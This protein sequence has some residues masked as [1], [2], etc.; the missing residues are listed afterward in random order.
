MKA[1]LLLPAMVFVLPCQAQDEKPGPSALEVPPVIEVMDK[2]VG[3]KEISGAVTFV[4]DKD[5]IVFSS[6][7]GF[8]DLGKK[9]AMEKDSIFWIASM[10]K[11]ITGTAVMMMQ[12]AGKLSVDDPVSKYLPEFKD[13]KDAEG[14]PV[15]ITIRQCLTHSSGLSDVRG[16]EV[17][18]VATLKDLMPRIVAKPVKFA[19][20]SKWEYCQSGI[21]AAGRIVEVVSGEDYPAFLAKHLFEPLGMKDTT[22]YPSVAQAARIATS[23]KRTDAGALE[24]TGLSFLG[25]KAVTSKDRYPLANGGL[26]STAEDYG[27]FGRMILRGGELDGKRYLKEESVKQMTTVQSGDLKTGFTPGNG[28]GLGWCVIREPQGVTA[29]VSPGTYGHGGAYGTQAWIDPVKERVY[30]MLVQRADFPNSDG[31]GLRKAFQEAAA[32]L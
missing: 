22:F 4:G 24:K 3:A 27:K 6:A 8:A 9:T 5:G 15:T 23:Y 10:T 17:E 30:V 13:L 29:A 32:G 16:P 31:S 11:P 14:K 26:F 20:G 19:P 25:N 2:A 7:N 12:E 1:L 18:G 21:N 28:W